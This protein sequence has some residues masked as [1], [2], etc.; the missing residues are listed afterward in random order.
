MTDQTQKLEKFKQAVLDEAAEKAAE[1]IKETEEQCAEVL[2]EAEA[3]ARDFVKQSRAKAE[4]E[5]K[6]AAQRTESAGRLAQR[7]NVL[8]ARQEVID[9][10]FSNVREKLEFVPVEHMD[11]VL[12]TALYEK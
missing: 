10:V 12:A 8:N 3:E 11:E 1:I 4:K 7:R 6:E 2:A 9:R 5:Q